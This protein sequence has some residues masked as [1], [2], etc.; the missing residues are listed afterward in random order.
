VKYTYKHNYKPE[1][2]S[3]K[4]FDANT[5][6]PIDFNPSR[7][8][9]EFNDAY[10][11]YFVIYYDDEDWQKRTTLLENQKAE[12]AR[13]K[14]IKDEETRIYVENK[15]RKAEKIQREDDIYNASHND[16][17]KLY[18]VIHHKVVSSEETKLSYRIPAYRVNITYS[19]DS[20]SKLMNRDNCKIMAIS[21]KQN[22]TYRR[23]ILLNGKFEGTYYFTEYK[24]FTES[25]VRGSF[26]AHQSLSEHR[27]SGNEL[28]YIGIVSS[29][30]MYPTQSW[31]NRTSEQC[32]SVTQ[33]YSMTY[34]NGVKFRYIDKDNNNIVVTVN[35]G[36]FDS[37]RYDMVFNISIEISQNK[38]N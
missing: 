29:H 5:K 35:K 17:Y 15:K 37:N 22:A 16:T 19:L 1:Q 24:N 13:L 10:K 32:Y 12:K 27:F 18:G 7:V 2:V 36:Y 14:Q 31:S 8:V 33:K 3:F 38:Q 34:K 28:F 25:S 20:E 11:R 26:Y 4:V 9:S 6:Q 21:T 30:T 23:D